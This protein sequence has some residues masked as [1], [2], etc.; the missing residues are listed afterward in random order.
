M[1]CGRSTHTAW[2][3]ALF[4]FVHMD[5]EGL[6]WIYFSH[7]RLD[8]EKLALILLLAKW[9]LIKPLERTGLIHVNCATNP[10][11]LKLD[12]YKDTM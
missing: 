8:S 5:T 9:I 12:S 6:E 3:Y 2:V 10:V 1:H 4:Y 11:N 7:L